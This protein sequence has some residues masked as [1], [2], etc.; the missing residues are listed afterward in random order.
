[1]RM[2][3]VLG[4]ILTNTDGVHDGRRTKINSGN[5]CH[6]SFIKLNTP[7]AFQNTIFFLKLIE[8]DWEQRLGKYLDLCVIK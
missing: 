4:T 5:V 2:F 6:Y 1:M 8:C 7:S 3:E